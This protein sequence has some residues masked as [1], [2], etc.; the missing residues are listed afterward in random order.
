MDNF[1]FADLPVW[2]LIGSPSFRILLAKSEAHL[3]KQLV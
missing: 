2:S 3:F 1:L